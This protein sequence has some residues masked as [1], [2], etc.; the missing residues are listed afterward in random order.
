MK[1]VKRKL[2]AG[3]AGNDRQI[4]LLSVS[5]VTFV[6]YDEWIRTCLLK[7]QFYVYSFVIK[8]KVSKY[9][10]GKRIIMCMS[11]FYLV[12]IY[13]VGYDIVKYESFFL[14]CILIV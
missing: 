6:L 9:N 12:V 7:L 11:I 10:I 4:L 1:N 3:L 5:L 13:I 14:L 8:M 2:S